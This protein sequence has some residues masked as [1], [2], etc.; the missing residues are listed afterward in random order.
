MPSVSITSSPDNPGPSSSRG[1]RRARLAA[2]FLEARHRG[3]TNQPLQRHQFDGLGYNIVGVSQKYPR[4]EIVAAERGTIETSKNGAQHRD[5]A[6]SDLGR[7]S[8]RVQI[9]A[10]SLNPVTLRVDQVKSS[11]PHQLL[12]VN[13]VDEIGDFRGDISVIAGDDVFE[14]TSSTQ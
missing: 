5:R 4:G 2:A 13:R 7:I 14:H 6:A 9:S 3:L 8:S 1:S 11:A 10:Q 12:S